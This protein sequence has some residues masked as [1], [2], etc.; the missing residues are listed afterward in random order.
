M[1]IYT[2][3]DHRTRFAAWAAVT[4]ARASKKC[5]FTRRQGMLIIERSGLSKF[6]R[7][8]DLPQ[9]HDFD[10]FHK[11]LR[12]DLCAAAIN[13][14]DK[15]PERFSHGVA[16]KLVNVYFKSLFL[17]GTSFGTADPETWAKINAL[18]PPIDRLLLKSLSTRDVGGKAS[19]WHRQSLRG[20]SNFT[21]E[22][23]EATIVEIRR[24]TEGALWKIEKYWLDSTEQCRECGPHQIR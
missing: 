11:G 22:D 16:A 4:A 17:S 24:V 23:Y 9:P 19:F 7:W 2:L 14:L 6:L 12:S 15:E 20:W 3:D 18:H 13:I 5:R 10:D 21:S 8:A 1:T